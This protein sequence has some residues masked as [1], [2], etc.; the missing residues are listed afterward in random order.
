MAVQGAPWRGRTSIGNPTSSA[1]SVS[2]RSQAEP[3]P[4]GSSARWTSSRRRP[5]PGLDPDR[6]AWSAVLHREN[7]GGVHVHVLAARCDLETGR[8]LNIAPPGWQKSFDPLRD[9]LNHEHEERSMA[10][11]STPG[12]LS[13]RLRKRRE[14]EERR[15]EAERQRYEA[16]ITNELEKL[17][18][19]ASS[20][21][22]NAQRSIESALEDV[23]DRQVSALKWSWLLP[24]AAG[25]TLFLLISLGSWGLARWQSSRIRARGETLERLDLELEERT[26]TLQQLNAGT[27]GIRLHEAENGKYIVLPPGSRTLDHNDRSAGPG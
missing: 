6:Y 20:A 18:A 16:L 21:A 3:Q 19:S 5:G 17:G 14:E 8:S 12:G 2:G 23:V 27:W 7:N 11:T 24:L 9:A 15:I 25:I 10:G 4:P 22:S 26:R 13:E 1:G